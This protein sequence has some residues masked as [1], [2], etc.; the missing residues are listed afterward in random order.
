MENYQGDD[1]VVSTHDIK[2]TLES[3]K[4]IPRLKSGIKGLDTL[5][6]G[7]LPG[8]MIVIT[9][10]TKMGKCLGRG[11]E[12][13]L[14]D[15]GKKNVEDIIRG[16]TLLGDDERIRNVLSTAQGRAKMY[17]VTLRNGDT[18]T[19]NED[20]ILSLRK[21]GTV[22]TLD[23]SVK[24]Y[25][26]RSGYFKHNWLA[27]K[28]L[29]SFEEKQYQIPPYFLGLWLGDG[30]TNSPTITTADKEIVE[31]IEKY[32]KKEGYRITVQPQKN[33]KSSTYSLVG[34]H[35]QFRKQLRGI[36]VLGNKHI[37]FSYKTGAVW[38]RLQLL[39]GL[40][41]SDGYASSC[42]IVFVNKNAIL[43]EDFI[44]LARS[45]GF[46]ANK[47]VF[48]VKGNPYYKVSVGGH[49]SRIPLLLK[50]K[51][52]YG[53]GQKK[54]NVLNYAFR[55]EKLKEDEYFGFTLDGNGRFL[56]ADFTVTHNTSLS[57]TLTEKFIEE[58]HN[59][60][61]FSYEEP[62]NQFL[63]SFDPLPVFYLPRQLIRKDAAWIE[64]RI[65]EAKTKYNIKAV[66]VDHLGYLIDA[67]Q[68]RN[69]ALEIG[70]IVRQIR[71]LALR[72]EIVLFLL[73]HVKR[74]SENK[75]PTH[76]DLRDSELIAAEASAVLIIW[77]NRIKGTY[78]NYSTL[79]VDIHRRTGAREKQIKLE[80]DGKRFQEVD[81]HKF[82]EDQP[83]PKF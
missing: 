56:L 81:P 55:V 31:W 62:Y 80:F 15:G 49:H 48:Y 27:Y 51:S 54:K 21:T 10:Q 79:S 43:I 3:F 24:D 30:S 83:V 8:E 75:N 69:A 67:F 23:I 77:R 14:F 38:Q 70:S 2:E 57:R 17:L 50:R 82:M 41:D 5:C 39:A 60:L 25:V 11:T 18:F 59:C 65:I 36:G 42:S 58:G 9:G 1:R 46:S 44:F 32:A 26:S 74:I 12:V 64:Q 19:C 22:Q 33:N 76:H 16:D 52:P 78:G 72:H 4:D 13:L 40:L 71:L 37:P 20:H 45:L 68:F 73:H 34:R 28:S 66:F 47:R 29:A 63:E 7:F 53:K 6:D 61:W 35:G